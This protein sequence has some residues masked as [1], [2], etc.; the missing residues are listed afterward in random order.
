[1]Y[2]KDKNNIWFMLQNSEAQYNSLEN[3][4]DYCK[5]VN[6]DLKLDQI[7]AVYKKYINYCINNDLI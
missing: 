6:P 5:L 1:M 7:K 3:A 2:L 4:Q